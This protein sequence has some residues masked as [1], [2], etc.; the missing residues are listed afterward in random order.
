MSRI[1]DVL[2]ELSQLGAV[3]NKPLPSRAKIAILPPVEPEPEPEPSPADTDADSD[4]AALTEGFRTGFD[5]DAD[6]PDDEAEDTPE[7]ESEEDEP[8]DDDVEEA[9][10]A[11]AQRSPSPRMVLRE[12]LARVE[13]LE[14][15]VADLRSALE[16]LAESM[17]EEV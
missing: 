1:T 9:V 3:D 2:A 16:I 10:P 12:A 15:M 17:G 8:T 14:A 7:D 11:P 13:T 6:D 4:I 5:G